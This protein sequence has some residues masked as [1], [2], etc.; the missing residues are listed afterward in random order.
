MKKKLFSKLETQKKIDLELIEGGTLINK[1]D[2]DYQDTSFIN[3]GGSPRFDY[4]YDKSKKGKDN[5]QIVLTS[6]GS[7]KPGGWS[8][9]FSFWN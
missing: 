4:V 9:D 6:E 5:L 1:S 3:G 8:I 2:V 7:D